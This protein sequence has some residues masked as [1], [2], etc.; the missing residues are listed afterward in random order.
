M[1]CEARKAFRTFGRHPIYQSNIQSLKGV[2][3]CKEELGKNSHEQFLVL[4]GYQCR[5]RRLWIELVSTR[6]QVI[7]CHAVQLPTFENIASSL[8]NNL[9]VLLHVYYTTHV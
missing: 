2:F 9:I 3:F 4:G 7:L 6:L 1:I 5:R 8:I